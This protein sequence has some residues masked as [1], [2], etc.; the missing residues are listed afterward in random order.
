PIETTVS[1]ASRR[2]VG[3]SFVGDQGGQLSLAFPG[4]APS[5]I[6]LPQLTPWG[7]AKP[8]EK[9]SPDFQFVGNWMHGYV[10]LDYGRDGGFESAVTENGIPS[11][12]SDLVAY[13][14]YNLK[15]SEGTSL[16]NANPGVRPP[17]FTIPAGT[18][19]G[20]YRLRFK[21]DW[22]NIDA[23][24]DAPGT[25]A[26][27]IIKNGGRIIDACVD[28]HGDESQ[29][30]I[31][32]A[33]G[34]SVVATQYAGQSAFTT[35]YGQPLA[36]TI[37]PNDGFQLV[38]L[39]ITAGY[40]NGPDEVNGTPQRFSTF[41]SAADLGQS[42]QLPAELLRAQVQ[43]TP[44][45]DQVSDIPYALSF[46]RNATPARN[47]CQ[48]RNFGFE[49]NAA[50]I[51]PQK[52]TAYELQQNG[53]FIIARAGESL[54]PTID[55]A[56]TGLNAYLYVDFNQDGAFTPHLTPDQLPLSSSELVSFSHYQGKNSAGATVDAQQISLPAFKLP[57]DVQPGVYRA[58]LKLDNNNLQ[59]DGS[60]QLLA[61]GGK[62]IDFL[63]QVSGEKHNLTLDSRH[64][65][66]YESI[67][68]A[69]APSFAY[70]ATLNTTFV[71]VLEGYEAD[72][73]E[74]RYGINVNGPQYIM[75]NRQWQTD[76]I[77]TS[78]KAATARTW[79]GNYT[80]GDLHLQVH[81]QNNS[82]AWK[83][84]F[85]DEFNGTDS[86]YDFSKWESVDRLSATWNRWVKNDPRVAFVSD[87]NLVTRAIPNPEKNTDAVDMWTGGVRTRGRF[88]FQYG[89]V[90]CRALTNP[91]V[92]NFP[93][94]WMMP[95]DQSKGW[96]AC[97]EIDIWEQVNEEQRS[98]HTIHSNWSYTLK[99]TT[100]TSTFNKAIPFDRY[101]TYGLE[102]NADELIWYV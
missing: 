73:I 39:H 12:G 89:K 76:T 32:S 9:I 22:N 21:V 44:L 52:T 74:V 6:Y 36:L 4:A 97:G 41:V 92:G 79:S 93:A 40:L 20:V 31:L 18:T 53:P 87:G 95:D 59:A 55:V 2:I 37:Y 70:G 96:P 25:E 102:W 77:T 85:E 11:A 24:G 63:I 94:I 57:N 58:R 29:V 49:N 56:G 82:S 7:A 35:A 42:P 86:A 3:V 28:I 26:N 65:N 27:N 84:I 51:A 81:F 54:A 15:N 64:G 91:F 75:G 50:T 16:P 43:I 13:S 33:N 8:G 101:H 1:H 78:I 46:D 14:S 83:P 100:P 19:F 60:A 5:T 71:P 98:H 61:E 17:A 90:E 10:Y 67:G 88:S 68:N 47:D 30:E 66:I 69:P 45:F 34:G 38:G 99:K 62:V 23:G 80:K 72:K 48:L